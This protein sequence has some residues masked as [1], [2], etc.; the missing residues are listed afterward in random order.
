MAFSRNRLFPS[1]AMILAAPAGLSADILTDSSHCVRLAHH[2]TPST[3]F[4]GQMAP[5]AGNSNSKLAIVAQQSQFKFDDLSMT[6]R[7]RDRGSSSESWTEGKF[8]AKRLDVRVKRRQGDELLSYI[9]RRL[10]ISISAL[11]SADGVI[12]N[13]WVPEASYSSTNVDMTK[14]VEALCFVV[15]LSICQ[16][17]SPSSIKNSFAALQRTSSNYF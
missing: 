5:L 1:L 13:L 4:I 7:K 9:W 3:S 17:L 11:A 14:Q 8:I 16:Q 2:S 6:S 15:H 12:D 10:L